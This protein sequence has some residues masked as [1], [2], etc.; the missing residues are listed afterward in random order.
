[1]V[2]NSDHSQI[3]A[4]AASWLSR[5][6]SS[7]KSSSTDR[8]VR[9]WLEES[10]DHQRAFERATEIWDML[11][12]VAGEYRSAPPAAQ[13]VRWQPWALA[14]SL[15]A[16]LGTGSAWWLPRPPSYETHIGEQQVVMLADNTRVALNTNSELEVR[17]SKAERRVILDHGEALFEVSH[18]ASR[19]CLGYSGADVVRA[20]GTRFVVRNENGE[21]RVTLLE[22]KVQ[23]SGPSAANRAPLAV[24]RPGQRLTVTADAGASL[25]TPPLDA[26]TAWRR[27]EIVFDNSTL[28]DAAEELNRYSDSHLVIADP[29]LASLRVSGVFSTKDVPEVAKAFA[30]LYGLEVEQDGKDY[31]LKS[32]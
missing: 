21:T 1:M 16:V 27:G 12:S 8:A 24:L 9:A 7:D 11:P 4:E 15:A 5:L 3:E 30:T 22:G 32:S 17:Y 14:A 19:P 26:A 23:V 6:H 28:I 29:R 25:D 31:K 2:T 20:I 13:K 10:E 18:E